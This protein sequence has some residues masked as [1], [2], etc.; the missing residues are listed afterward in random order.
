MNPKVKILRILMACVA[1]CGLA[2]VVPELVLGVLPMLMCPPLTDR[3]GTCQPGTQGTTV[4]VTIAGVTNGTCT[5]CA[6]HNGTFT[7]TA[8]PSGGPCF[9]DLDSTMTWCGSGGV[10]T[11]HWFTWGST[12]TYIN[13][14]TGA[15]QAEWE[16]AITPLRDCQDETDL[17][18]ADAPS[19]IGGL[20]NT[21]CNWTAATAVIVLGPP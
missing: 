9:Y 8:D 5:D 19:S 17:F 21:R 14:I 15:G 1:V 18:G 12:T 4:D 20:Y 13:G 7:M 16:E 11:F 10:A 3:C 2:L 6:N